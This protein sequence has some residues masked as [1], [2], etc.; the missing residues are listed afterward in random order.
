MKV[1]I[2]HI[3]DLHIINHKNDDGEL[4]SESWLTTDFNAYCNALNIYIKRKKEKY[5]ITRFI[6]IVSGDL[7]RMENAVN[8]ML[9]VLT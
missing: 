7:K 9:I 8:H 2:I 5:G 4:I 1:A 6:L 3:S